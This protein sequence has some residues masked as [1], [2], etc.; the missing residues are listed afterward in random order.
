MTRCSE[1]FCLQT[2]SLASLC[3]AAGAKHT[4][5]SHLTIIS[6]SALFIP[7][8]LFTRLIPLSHLATFHRPR[9][10][11][12]LL[13]LLLLLPYGERVPNICC[14]KR[15]WITNV[16]L[17]P[18]RRIRELYAEKE[19]DDDWADASGLAR[20]T[21][22]ATVYRSYLKR[23]ACLLHHARVSV[24]LRACS[25]VCLCACMC[26]KAV[27]LLPLSTCPQCS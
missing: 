19:R 11:L 2:L 23:C 1:A 14:P 5:L 8:T 18:Y 10:K 25:C 26:V 27:C 21:L 16:P 12:L 22:H 17:R 15:S 9:L 7:R 3:M 24:C 6:R 4:L 20:Q 13:L